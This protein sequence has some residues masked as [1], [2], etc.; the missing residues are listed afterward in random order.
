MASVIPTVASVPFAVPTHAASEPKPMLVYLGTGARGSGVHRLQM[1]PETGRLTPLDITAIEA[2]GWIELDRSEQFLFA[3]IA[4]SKVASFAIDQKT[5]SLSLIGTQQNGASGAPHLSVDRTGRFVVTASYGGGSVSLL[6][7]APDGQ[8][9]PIADLVLHQ[10]D[11]GPHRD[12]S[13]PRAHQCPFD[14]TRRWIA[15]PDLGLDRVYVYRL[16]G[17][18]AKLVANDPAFIQFERGRGPRHIAFHPNGRFAYLINELNSTMTA[19]AWDSA[20]GV[21]TELNTL[22][23]LPPGWTG[24]QWS[25]QVVVHPN[26]RFVYGSNRGSGGDSDD[27]AIF[28]IDQAS[29]RI[30]PTGHAETLGKVPRNF[31]IDPSGRFLICAHQDSDNVVPFNINAETGALTPIGQSLPV[32]NAICVQFAPGIA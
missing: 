11:P 20:T 19:L 29:G 24:R 18:N 13:Q 14:L 27:I 6:P 2:P 1:D 3:T 32:I 25:A 8:V 15:V 10:G 21:F 12:Q 16:D 28:A 31:V 26:G 22:T 9:G 17:V 7:V 5:G 23:T 4:G 30:S